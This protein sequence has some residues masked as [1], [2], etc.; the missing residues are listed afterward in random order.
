[1][2]KCITYLYSL[3][4]AAIIPILLD[5]HRNRYINTQ[6]NSYNYPFNVILLKF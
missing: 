5:R 4:L 2:Y 3:S 1:M 6:D